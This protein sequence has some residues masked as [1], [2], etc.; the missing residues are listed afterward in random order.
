MRWFRFGIELGHVNGSEHI[1]GCGSASRVELELLACGEVVVMV[2]HMPSFGC[3]EFPSI[4][5]LNI[6]LRIIGSPPMF[7]HLFLFLFELRVFSG[8]DAGWTFL[9]TF[10]AANAGVKVAFGDQ[11]VVVGT[12]SNKSIDRGAA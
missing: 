11:F 3:R 1:E 8:F 12:G 9:D 5:R 4:G 7:G 6:V 2:D 10:I